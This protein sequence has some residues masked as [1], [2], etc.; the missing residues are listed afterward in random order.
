MTDDEFEA[1]LDAWGGDLTAWPAPERAAATALLAASPLA[2]RS[3]A[4]MRGV[5]K[6]LARTSRREAPGVDGLVARVTAQAQERAARPRL[7]RLRYA[8]IG[9]AV[10]AAGYAYGA[11]TPAAA[12]DWFGPAF[13]P[14]EIFDVN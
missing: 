12:E 14:A 6:A 3:L 10:L 2:R 11:L 8:V 1:G 4:A 9:L 5:E 7:L 13:A